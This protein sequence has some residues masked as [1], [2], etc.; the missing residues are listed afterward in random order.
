MVKTISV[1]VNLKGFDVL[2]PKIKNALKTGLKKVGLNIERDAKINAPRDTG[3]LKRMTRARP[4]KNLSLVVSSDTHYAEY[5]EQPGNVRKEGIRPFMKP[6][7]LKNISK[8]KNI[9]TQELRRVLK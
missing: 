4:V 9:L 3:H 7:L 8:I 1:K 2:E 5:M 6:A